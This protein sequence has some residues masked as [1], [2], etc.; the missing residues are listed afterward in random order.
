MTRASGNFGAIVGATA[1]TRGGYRGDGDEAA[2][3]AALSALT[4]ACE[5][6]PCLTSASRTA[7]TQAVSDGGA[8]CARTG[9]TRGAT[10][11]ATAGLTAGGLAAGGC[12]SAF[13]TD[14]VSISFSFGFAP[15][16]SDFASAC[17][18]A[19]GC[20]RSDASSRL[21]AALASGSNA[22]QDFSNV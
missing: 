13:R 6:T 7:E 2:G 18:A 3:A 16:F 12:G 11:L 21:N 8:A 1:S 20:T 15:V 17:R 5:S 14:F 22:P 9:S 10:V 4:G 19:A